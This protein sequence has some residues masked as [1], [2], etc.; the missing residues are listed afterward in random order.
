MTQHELK[1]ALL[2]NKKPL[3][4][5]GILAVVVVLVLGGSFVSWAHNKMEMRKLIR[6]SAQLDKEHEALREH[7]KHLEDQDPSY[8]EK[9]ARTQYHMVKPGE[10]EFRFRAE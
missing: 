2:A 7:L 3:L 4:L 5:I 6:Q 10:I 9:I 1:S 8:I